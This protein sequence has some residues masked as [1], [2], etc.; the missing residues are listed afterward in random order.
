MDLI[1]HSAKCVSDFCFRSRCVGGVVKAPVVAV[2]LTRKQWTG[3]IGIPAD[4]D[5]GIDVPFQ[6]LIHVF[7][8]VGRN[9][10][11]DFG[12]SSDRLGVNIARRIRSR[13]MH[14][15]DIPS[16][17]AKDTFG[18]VTAAGVT[19]AKDEDGGFHW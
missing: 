19:R 6:K 5:D 11:P 4:R 1:S 14:S 10:D 12:K 9:I 16:C 3:L 17:R 2:H 18:H 15:N 8:G 7:R 13:A